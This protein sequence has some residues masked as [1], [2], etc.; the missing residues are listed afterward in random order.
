MHLNTKIYVALYYTLFVYVLVL[1]VEAIKN[2][3]FFPVCRYQYIK[4]I[5]VRWMG[6]NVYD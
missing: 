1:I 4:Q 5:Y 3:L 2:V 6:Y